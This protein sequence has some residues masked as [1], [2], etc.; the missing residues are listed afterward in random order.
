MK[1]IFLC[2]LLS[3]FSLGFSQNLLTDLRPG[4]DGSE[5]IFDNAKQKGNELF[6]SAS[7][8]G[9]G[10]RLYKT[11]GSSVTVLEGD[12]NSWISYTL[13]GF[14]GN[15]LIYFS[16]DWL[17]ETLGIYKTDGTPG[18]GELILNFNINGITIP[19]WMNIVKDGTMYFYGF[20]QNTGYE[21]WK[22][23]GTTSG[24][25]MIKDINP[26]TESSVLYLYDSDATNQYFSELN[27]YIYFGAAE[28]INGAELWRTDGTEAGTTMVAN[29]EPSQPQIPQ[30]GSNPAFFCTYNNAVYFS[31][32]RI[33]DGRELW[34]TDGTAAGT[35]QVKDIASGDAYPSY[36][37]EYNGSLYFSAY[38]PDQGYTLYKSNGTN[39]GTV[40]VKAPDNGGPEAPTPFVKFKGK[41]YFSG[42]YGQHIWYTD[43]TAA[44]TNFLPNGSLFNSGVSNL[45]ATTNYIYFMANNGGNDEVYRTTD[46]PNQVTLLTN[47]SFIANN[48][49]P[50]FLVNNCLLVRGE[51]GTAGDEIYTVCSQNTQPVGLDEIKVSTPIAFPNPCIDKVMVTCEFDVATIER[52]VLYDLSGNTMELSFESLGQNAMS[53]SGLSEF[54]EGIYFLS[55]EMNNGQQQQIKLII[56]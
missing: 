8:E 31:A 48:L 25:Y 56:E 32:Y 20:D 7:P 34:K 23:D 24:T 4:M 12:A 2:L 5:P 53:I 47:P 18:S 26:G 39:A 43:G 3:Q 52:T 51:D 33:V 13:L 38:H 1:K 9:Q 19:Y 49:Y 11:N 27:G 29:I 14:I 6:F 16:S 17:N 55:I 50:M 22:T 54:S 45:L 21:L 30:M 42:N 41:L 40:V 28:P 35:V 10:S 46:L 44:G 37:T 36:M 15:D